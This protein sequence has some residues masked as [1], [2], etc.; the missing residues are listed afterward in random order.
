MV[1]IQVNNNG[2]LSNP[3]T[4]YLTDALP[5]VFTQNETGIGFASVLHNANYSLVTPSNPAVAGE[6]IDIYLTGLGTVTPVVGDGAVGPGLTETIELCRSIQCDESQGQFRRL[7]PATY[8]P[9]P[10]APSVLP[11]WRPVSRDSTR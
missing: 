5:G 6:Y 9:I 1:T 8:A 7:Q 10:P 2:L 4:L 11:G 3:V